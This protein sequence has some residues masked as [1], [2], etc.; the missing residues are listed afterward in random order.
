MTH[1]AFPILSLRSMTDEQLLTHCRWEAFRGPG[2][3]GQKRNKTSSAIR[4][5][6]EAT[7]LSSIATDT[8]SQAKNRQLALAR[9][10]HRLVVEVRQ[11]LDLKSF[12]LPAWYPPLLD[13]AG[14]LRLSPRSEAYLPAA[15][16]VLDVLSA[17]AWSVSI[18]A[19]ALGLTTSNLAAF[20]GR[21]DKLLAKVNQMRTATG[22]KPLGD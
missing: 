7:G 13:N 1:D 2:P 16:L 17:S 8:R 19:R 11:P 14:R 20:L 4:I 5:T 9:L 6:H 21:D 3:G 18:A 10:R 12:S 15:G 22:L